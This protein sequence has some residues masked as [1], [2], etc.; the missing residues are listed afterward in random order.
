MYT[1]RQ[2]LGVQLFCCF[3]ILELGCPTRVESACA[4]IRG[5]NAAAGSVRCARRRE[6]RSYRLTSHRRADLEILGRRIAGVQPFVSG[7]GGLRSM[8]EAREA[9]SSGKAV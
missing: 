1:K 6:T 9:D 4:P 2:H 3:E 5:L 7:I 8:Q